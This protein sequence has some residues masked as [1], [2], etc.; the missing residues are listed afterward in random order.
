[1]APG[2]RAVQRQYWDTWWCGR[3]YV[4]EEPFLLARAPEAAAIEPTA[5]TAEED[6]ALLGGRWPSW[7]EIQA[8]ADPLEPPTLGDALRALDPTGPWN[9]R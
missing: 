5:L 6:G 7:P 9:R 3:H 8:L 2:S 1:M 4:G